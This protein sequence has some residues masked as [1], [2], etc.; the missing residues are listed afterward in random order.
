MT[1]R[2]MIV[3]VIVVQHA[4]VLLLMSSHPT[5]TGLL[6]P[7]AMAKREDL[8]LNGLRILN[9]LEEAQEVGIRIL[10][11]KV[12]AIT[13]MI[14]IGIVQVGLVKEV[15]ENLLAGKDKLIGM[16]DTVQMLH[17]EHH[18]VLVSIFMINGGKVVRDIRV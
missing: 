1:I 18:T 16:M 4:D 3:V 15:K 17:M 11:V 2:I 9:I 7:V 10:R 14:V 13:E 5:L 8:S 6:Q 12:N